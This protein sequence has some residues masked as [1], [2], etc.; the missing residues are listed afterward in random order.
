MK[1]IIIILLVLPLVLLAQTTPSQDQNYILTTTYQ[2]GYLKGQEQNA[3]NEEQLITIGYFDGLGRAI[4][5]IEVRAGG[6]KED[7]VTFIDYDGYG[8]QTK[9]YLP[10]AT[11]STGGL[12]KTDALNVTASFYNTDK[13][14]N[15]YNPFSEKLIEASP[16][17]RVL[18][19]ASPGNSWSISSGHTIRFDYQTNIGNQGDFIKKLGVGFTGGDTTLPYLTTDGYYSDG[20]LM[21]TVTKDENWT[22]GNDHTVE[23]YKNNQ[24]QVILKR[25][26]NNNEIFDTQYVYDDYGNLTFVIPPKAM[27]VIFNETITTQPGVYDTTTTTFSWTDFVSDPGGSGSGSVTAGIVLLPDGSH[28]YSITF[29]LSSLTGNTLKTGNVVALPNA[30]SL[31]DQD[32]FNINIIPYKFAP[33]TTYAYK[34]INGYI[35]VELVSGSPAAPYG[36]TKQ[37]SFV[38]PPP[39]GD[40]TASYTATTGNALDDLCYQ[41]KYDYRNRLIEKKIPGK[42][43][44]YIVYDRIDRPILTQDANQRLANQWSFTK[45]DA[46]G[47]VV[48]TGIYHNTNLTGR[49]VMQNLASTAE[50]FHYENKTSSGTMIDGVTVYYTNRSFPNDIGALTVLTIN[51]YDNYTFDNDG[52]VLPSSVEGQSIVNY[53]NATA[54]QILTNGLSTGSKVRIL[55]TTDWIT[56]VMGYDTKGRTIYTVSKNNYLETT[57]I[58]INKL[59]FVGKVDKTTTTHTKGTQATITTT[60]NF[61]Y[62]HAGRLIK[63][64][65]TLAGHTETIVVNNYDELGQLQSKKVGNTETAPLQTVDYTYNIRG[66]LKQINN[67]TSLGSD[68]FG[69]K[70]GYDEGINPLYNGNISQTQWKTANTDNSL[71]TYDYTYDAL[72]RI[73]SGI[74]NTNDQRYSLTN[75]SYDK[76]GNITHLQRRGHT[77]NLN[78]VYFDIMDDL[79]YYYNGNQLHSVTDSA[80]Y[81]TGFDDGNAS[82]AIF[83][84]GN[85][86]YIYDVNGNLLSD[87][88]K[89]ITNIA[90][91]HLN[92][93]TQ[94]TFNDGNITYIYDATGVKQKKIVSTGATTE[95]AGNYVYENG[96]LQFFNTAEGYVEPSGSTYSYVYQYKDH[97]GNIRL[98][99]KN[100]S[101]TSIPVLQIVEENN[102]YPFGLRHKGY[103]N[104]VTSTNIAQN[105]K[106]NGK[107]LNESLG[108]NWYD[109]GA[110]RYD[111]AIGRWFTLDKMADDEMQ[112]DKTPYAYSWNSPV[113]LNDPDGN[114]PWCIG[115]LVG[116]ATEYLVQAGTNL[117]KGQDLGDALWNNIDGADVLIAA[118]EGALTG[119][120]SAVRRVAVT[121]TAEVVKS[122]IDVNLDGS[123]DVIGTEG[124]TKTASG[125]VKEAGVNIVAGEALG[126][127]D[128]SGKLVDASSDVAVKSAKS[129]VTAKA[130]NLDKANNIRR[131]GN[132]SEAARGSK[133]KNSNDAFKDFN[134]AKQAQSTTKALNSTV[135]KVN[136]NVVKTT[137][138]SAEGTVYNTIK[139]DLQKEK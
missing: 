115:A 82:D 52:L 17:N 20:S 58:V 19:Q 10:Y 138:N 86:D 67:P 27:D 43:P 7:I 113:T 55:E 18:E 62:D 61:M 34:I 91:N 79:N 92:L 116:A 98:S 112:I 47:R 73:T 51:Y 103:N 29:N 6:N 9:E 36:I 81:S 108:L 39:V 23:E 120:A 90:Y 101:T 99:Y 93:P 45:Y 76:N 109:Y 28:Q 80:V 122:A 13:Y 22:S 24:G 69:F 64:T 117:A 3:T 111:P 63:Q 14:E 66:W 8:R 65:Q 125:V 105:W 60:D 107:E 88:N 135:G 96:Q 95:Y 83:N 123:T 110:R 11:L 132:A 53:N 56:T 2:K 26:Y 12:F 97:L 94:V 75:V 1:K 41:Y 84:N 137:V 71:K 118:G 102:Y 37:N 126:K 119:G 74:D 78:P 104:V 114:C 40:T 121:V 136:D 54:T 70:I 5:N 100:V 46:L 42:G 57:D 133:A 30:E 4:Q 50:P 127:I 49:L 38:L 33:T 16:L 129:N 21:K 131:T 48:Y 77:D 106:Y 68:L 35:N 134:K 31:G 128:L 59:D 87:A 44:E 139:D 32:L 15:T 72:N 124:S 130:K 25:S 85:D 89:G